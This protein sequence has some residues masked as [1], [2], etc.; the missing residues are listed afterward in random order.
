MALSSTI[1]KIEMDIS[2]LDRHYYDTHSLTVARHPSETDERLVARLIAFALNASSRLQFGMSIGAGD[3]PDLVEKDYAGD[4]SLWIS[5]GCPDEKLIKKASGRSE[6]VIIYCYGG[7]EVEVWWDKL[8][9]DKLDKVS[10]FRIPQSVT[11]ALADKMER[12]SKVQCTIEDGS[13]WWNSSELSQEI[14]C[15]VLKK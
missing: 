6:R 2:D 13:L 3:E 1:F 9:I 14:N 7:T 15:S 11:S 4:I 10:I 12:S 5:V 8:K